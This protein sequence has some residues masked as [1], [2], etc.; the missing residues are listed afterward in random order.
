MSFK[1][2]SAYLRPFFELLRDA[3]VSVADLR[4]SIPDPEIPKSSVEAEAFDLTSADIRLS[5]VI[6]E[7]WALFCRFACV[8]L[9]RF[10]WSDG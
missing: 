6:E 8:K 7:A 4:P 5:T 1:L 3:I 10:A 2:S 9:F